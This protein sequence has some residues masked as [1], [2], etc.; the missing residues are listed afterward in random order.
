M[1]RSSLHLLYPLALLSAALLPS[2]LVA[3]DFP[4]RLLDEPIDGEYS[5]L[6]PVE[7]SGEGEL[8]V[9]FDALGADELSYVRLAGGKVAVFR[10]SADAT[11]RAGSPQPFR[12]RDDLEITVQRRVGRVR[13][14]AAGEVLLD[15]P[16][17]GP[18]QGQVGVGDRGNV[19]AG[20]PLLQPVA[21]PILTDDFTREE[22][23]MAYWETA[24]GAFRN[25]MVQVE[26]ADPA[27]SANPFSLR[28]QSEG[29]AL[30]TTGDWFWDSY[31]VSASVK[32]RDVQAV[33]LCAYVQDDANYLALRWE[34]GADNEPGARQ[35]VLVCD[36]QEQV[37]DR[38]P[39]GFKPEEWYRLELRVTPGRVEA[40]IDRDPALSADTTAFGQGGIGLWSEAGEALFDD[41]LVQAPDA[42]GVVL[43]QINPVFT[44]D[45]VM[46][47]QQVY[48][49]RG[50]WR[51]GGVP[52]EYWHWG[53]FF[54]DATVSVPLELLQGQGLGVLLRAPATDAVTGYRV[55]ARARDGQ[56]ALDLARSGQ[57]TA[58]AAERLSGEEPLSIGV[59]GA[60]VTVSQGQRVL[61]SHMD[62]EPL[63]GD[64]VA[65]LDAPAEATDLVTVVSDHFRDYT[66]SSGPTDWFAGKGV[67]DV[68]ARWHCD[69]GWTFLGGTASQNPV[70]W[71]KHGYRGDI[72]LEFFAAIR[73]EENWRGN[74]YAYIHPSDINATLCGDGQRLDGGYSFVLAG[75][76]NSRSAILRNGEIVAETPDAI[77][78]DPSTRD[79]FHHHWFR[80]RAEKLGGQIRFWV[81]GELILEY[82]D[83]SPLPGGRV[84][85]WSFHNDLV[86]A[87]ARLWFAQEE[88]PGGV[89]RVPGIETVSLQ[90]TPRDRSAPA[91]FDDFE[92]SSGEWWVP[93]D[94]PGALVALDAK[95]AASG[96]QSLRVT[97][98]DEGGPFT[99]YPVTTPFRISDFPVLSFDYRLTPDVKLNLYF[100]TNGE[101][102]ALKLT[103]EQFPGDGVVVIGEVPDLQADGRWHHA[104]VN[105]FD[106][107]QRA[108]PQFKVFQ[109]KQFALSPPWESY[110]RCGIGGNHRGTQYWVDNFRLGPAE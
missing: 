87:R 70:L 68:T 66:F 82:T 90:P 28:V 25:T 43:P 59:R 92:T 53:E 99:V 78:A 48:L 86:V 73:M 77:F 13:V 94:A 74:P 58:S 85:L 80:V 91:V 76:R 35:L 62:P 100:Y 16:W 104:E 71:T 2:S 60:T 96:R 65:L 98:Q 9:A 42:G 69:P 46:A 34:R 3:D 14:I 54:D 12:A 89:V 108:Y 88:Q 5:V 81:D 106:L 95:T 36:G 24:G 83:S 30:A 38:A 18:L 44:A 105:L 57:P 72:V 20:E 109:V 33:G 75:W 47:A 1:R 26:G 107:M 45:E 93:P 11:V 51:M 6:C 49:P 56:L 102:H 101:W 103:A 27:R 67:W 55:M 52:G 23:E 32:P 64:H 17:D 10:H 97:N 4:Y 84:G 41:A 15:L 39:G 7:I 21:D 40:L 22:A 110:T 63:V 79:E 19:V 61:L 50:F 37:L 8:R 29:E 31:H